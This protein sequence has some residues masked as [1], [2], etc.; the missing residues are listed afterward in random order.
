[1]ELFFFF[2]FFFK[3]QY[4]FYIENYTIV[5]HSFPNWGPILQ[6]FPEFWQTMN[7]LG[8]WRL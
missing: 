4:N 7:P 5:G 2:C 8:P 3:F 6:K 1:M